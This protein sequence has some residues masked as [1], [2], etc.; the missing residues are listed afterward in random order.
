MSTEQGKTIKKRNIDE[1]LSEFRKNEA[2]TNEKPFLLV[3]IFK[4]IPK[5]MYSMALGLFMVTCIS[6]FTSSLVVYFYG[7][8]PSVRPCTISALISKLRI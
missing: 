3:K 5:W 7:V 2:K 8:Q 6:F 1:D 4:K